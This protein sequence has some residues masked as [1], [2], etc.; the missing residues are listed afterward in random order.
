M[1]TTFDIFADETELE[2]ALGPYK[3]L[4]DVEVYFTRP[5]L[6][7]KEAIDNQEPM[8][9]VTLSKHYAPFVR[10]YVVGDIMLTIYPQG[11]PEHDKY[12]NWAKRIISREA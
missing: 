7:V 12:A 11:T 8:L 1:K 3:P 6:T 9:Q 4:N 10:H 5:G 2:V